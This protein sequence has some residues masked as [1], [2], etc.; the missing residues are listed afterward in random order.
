MKEARPRVYRS[1]SQER[2]LDVRDVIER[3]RLNHERALAR[4]GPPDAA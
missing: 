4:H 1:G 3:K 2:E